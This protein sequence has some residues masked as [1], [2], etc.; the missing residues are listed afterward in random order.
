[1]QISSQKLYESGELQRRAAR[2]HSRME[3]CDICPRKCRVN[4]LA[5]E[6]GFCETGKYARIAS[7]GTHFGEEKVLVGKNGSGTIFFASCSLRCCFCQNFHTSHHPEESQEADSEMLAAIMLELQNQGCHNINFVT[8]THVVPQI[9]KALVI[10]VGK[11]LS[12]PLIYNCSGYENSTTIDLLEDVIDIYMPDFK[13]WNPHYSKKYVDAVAYPEIARK[14]LSLMH[15][16]VGALLIDI[17][18][19]ATRGL[20]VRHLVMPDLLDDTESILNF[21]STSISTDTYINIMDQYRPCGNSGKYPEL[22]RSISPEEYS[23]A[24]E[25]AEK[26]GLKR[27]HRRDFT[28]I[29]RNLGII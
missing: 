9:L 17:H 21:I 3:K 23:R 20:L 29:L 6:Q 25:S 2:A 22:T 14:A 24:M 10:A 1:M 4:R 5:G 27:I 18:G 8:P 16:Q 28:A 19:Q 7:Y 13:F 12:V 26:A 15:K 11:G